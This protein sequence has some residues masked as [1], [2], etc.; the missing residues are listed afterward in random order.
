MFLAVAGLATF[1]TACSSDDSTPNPDPQPEPGQL[2]VSASKLTPEVGETVTFTVKEGTADVTSTSDIYVNGNKISDKKL[3][4]ATAGEFKIVAKKANSKDSAAITVKFVEKG[5]EL[6]QLV[7]TATPSTIELNAETVFKVTLDNADVTST[8]TIKVGGVA[9]TGGKYKGT[10]AGTFKAV[11]SMTGAKD[12]AEVTITV[13][14]AVVPEP[15]EN[16]LK[17]DGNVIDLKGTALYQYF[18]VGGVNHNTI[19]FQNAVYARFDYVTLSREL[20]GTVAAVDFENYIALTVYVKQTV[21]VGAEVTNQNVVRPWQA[22]ANDVLFG[23]AD[24]A[25]GAVAFT[26]DDEVSVR[27]AFGAPTEGSG[28]WSFSIEDGFTV[29]GNSLDATFEGPFEGYYNIVANPTAARAK[30]ISS[31]KELKRLTTSVKMNKG[32]VRATK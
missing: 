4:S 13:K 1:G 12:S 3:T 14:P 2:V 9:V 15:T 18:K 16:F 29:E 17:V 23:G 10:V 20:T 7:L 21:A 5:T 32:A 28:V 11:A 30:N 8:A 6:K 31:V 25:I 22:A 24:G 19:T 27:W 26:G